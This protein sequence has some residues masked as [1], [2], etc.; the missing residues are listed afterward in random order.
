[1][2]RRILEEQQNQ[3]ALQRVAER[4]EPRMQHEE[5][6]ASPCSI[7]EANPPER[8]AQR[9]DRIT[10]YYAG[11]KMPETTPTAAPDEL[12]AQAIERAPIAVA[13]D[14]PARRAFRSHHRY[15]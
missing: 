9:L 13:P 14:H 11:D 5:A 7:A 8:I 12:L 3:A 1:M 10:R 4:A 6:L 2:R 15:L